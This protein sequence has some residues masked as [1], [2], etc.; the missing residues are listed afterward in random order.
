MKPIVKQKFNLYPAHVKSKME[1]LR[2]LIFDTAKTTDGVGELEETL[3]WNDLLIYLHKPKAV[4][5]SELTGN[6]NNR[7]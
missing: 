1:S 5:L 4:R 7:T 6:P 2:S 3:K